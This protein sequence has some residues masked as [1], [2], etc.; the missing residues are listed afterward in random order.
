MKAIFGFLLT[1]LINTSVSQDLKFSDPVPLGSSINS[2]SEEVNALLSPDGKTLYFVRAFDRR[3]KGGVA[4]GMDIWTS[5]RDSRGRFSTCTNEYKKWN[6]KFNNSVIGIRNDNHVLYM[7]NSYNKKSGIAFSKY[8]EGEWT[9]PEV[10]LIPGIDQIN[11]V[12]FYMHPS[13]SILLISSDRVG[14]YGKEDIYVSLKDSLDQWSDPLNL[15]NTI[16]TDGFEI[17]PFLSEDGKR[18]YFSSNGHKGYGD[19]DIFVSERLYNNWTLWTRPKNLGSKINSEKFD[20]YFSIYGDSVCYFSSNQVSNFSDIY[21]SKASFEKK[22]KL[23]DSVNRIIDETKKLLNELK[24]SDELDGFQYISSPLNSVILSNLMQ[25]QIK[26]LLSSYNLNNLK[27]I[28]LTCYRLHS[29]QISN[30]IDYM[31]SLGVGRKLIK[32][33][34]LITSGTSQSGVELKLFM[35]PKD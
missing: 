17:S 14:S 21:T 8:L 28:E 10:I 23:S 31:V 26:K 11:L 16:N 1:V 2:E 4:G 20:A 22:K 12:G 33:P 25:S 24:T 29:D 35:N 6:N 18:L 15:G 19:A 32:D 9:S 5:V 27:V 30:I 13:F 7:L 3:N 34:S